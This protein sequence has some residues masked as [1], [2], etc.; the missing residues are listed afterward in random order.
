MPTIQPT[1]TTS[2][3]QKPIALGDT[4]LATA[5]DGSPC[6]AIVIGVN[7]DGTVNLHRHVG[8]GISPQLNVTSGTAAGA[9]TYQVK[10]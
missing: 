5:D 9:G 4:V 1:N 3:P 10:P 2:T 8:N 6:A 7:S